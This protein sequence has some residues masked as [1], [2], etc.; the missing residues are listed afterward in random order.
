MTRSLLCFT[1]AICFASLP[2]LADD[3]PQSS[4]SNP[5]NWTLVWA[6]EFESAAIDRTKWNFDV[7]CW[8]GGNEERQCYTTL[9]T[10][11]AIADGKLQ[12]IAQ[13]Q[14]AEGPALPAHMRATAPEEERDATLAQ[15]FTSARLNTKGLA[16]WTYGRFEARAKFP[17]GQ[18][19]WAAIWMLPTEELYGAWA[20][21]GEIDI[22]EAVN[23][24]AG[25][26]ECDGDIENRVLGT[27][28]YGDEWPRNKYIGEHTELPPSEDGFHTYAVEWEQDKI[29]WYVDGQHY[30]TLTSKDWSS[31][32]L[33]GGGPKSEPFDQPFHLILN[34]AVGG[35]LSEQKNDG[36]I[37]L[38]DFP[39]TMEVDWVRVF[40]E[41]LAN[42]TSE[43]IAQ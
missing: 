16:D 41:R 2:A 19:L 21:S 38:V 4:L 14:P 23:L 34:L 9:P 35:H 43:A 28:H 40:Q 6:D 32:T 17:T 37:A 5:E 8:G 11:A 33:F 20:A 12:I 42:P 39:K 18:G 1:A 10:N 3:H 24:G 13:I 7:D 30:L 26:R 25:C 22:V 15:P 36:G 27:I 29:A 31:R